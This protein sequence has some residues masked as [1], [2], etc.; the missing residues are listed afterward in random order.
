MVV[1]RS[2]WKISRRSCLER[3][4][5]EWI[6]R[7]QRLVEQE[8]FGREHER[9]HQAHALPL[10]TGELRGV[11]PEGVCREARK[12]AEFFE[13][14]RFFQVAREQENIIARGQV[15][16]KP[17]ILDDVAGAMAERAHA[18]GG[19]CFAV[20]LYG[21]AVRHEQTNDQAQEGR[22]ATAAWPE[23]HGRE[24]A[25]E[26]EVGGVQRGVRAVSFADAAELNQRAQ[27]QVTKWKTAKSFCGS[28]QVRERRKPAVAASG[29]KA[30]DGVFVRILGDDE[31][32]LQRNSKLR[33]P[34]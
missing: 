11:A 17:A 29:C 19:D 32:A 21:A 13:R 5:N 31:F 12:R 25:L 33:P 22:L 15:R 34:R 2:R 28:V 1:C 14:R 24:A 3:R 6:E 26:A 7:A 18:L 10:A 4:P 16:E 20:K 27:S 8:Q 23:E 30:F 9:S